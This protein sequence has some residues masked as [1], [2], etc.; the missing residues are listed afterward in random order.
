MPNDT[1]YLP[2]VRAPEPLSGAFSVNVTDFS[3]STD[4][5]HTISTVPAAKPLFCSAETGILISVPD[6]HSAVILSAEMIISEA[7]YADVGS[8]KSGSATERSTDNN[9][10]IMM[11][12]PYFS[13]SIRYSLYPSHAA[14]ARASIIASFTSTLPSR[15]RSAASISITMPSQPFT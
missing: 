9:R 3:S 15:S 8:R 13:I 1:L 14:T 12:S 2:C 10:F 4:L 11:L 5:S 7:A 6:L